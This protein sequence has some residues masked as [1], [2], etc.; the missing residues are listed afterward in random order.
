M[1]TRNLSILSS[2]LLCAAAH[3]VQILDHGA[4]LISSGSGGTSVIKHFDRFG[5]FVENYASGGGMERPHG[6][7][8]GAEPGLNFH[9]ANFGGGNVL[10]FNGQTGNLI[11]TTITNLVGL[12][13]APGHLIR[14]RDEFLVCD[15]KGGGIKRFKQSDATYLGDFAPPGYFG[16]TMPSDIMQSPFSDNVIFVCST[17]THQVIRYEVD[18]GFRVATNPTVYSGTAKLIFPRGIAWQATRMLVTDSFNNRIVKIADGGIYDGVFA[19]SHLDNPAGIV[20]DPLSNAVYVANQGANN[21]VKFR[22]DGTYEGVVATGNGL[23]QPTYFVR[24][25]RSPSSLVGGLLS[26]TG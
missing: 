23:N 4:L 7:L 9:V 16:L 19:D 14:W 12:L 13:E 5:N 18:E 8:L 17:G 24:V 3:C 20:V 21:V 25:V 10:E 26:R 11:G 15:T 2:A 22:Y 1:R 6:I